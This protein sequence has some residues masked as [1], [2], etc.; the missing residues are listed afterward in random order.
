MTIADK[1]IGMEKFPGHS[2]EVQRTVDDVVLYNLM[3]LA[4]T[5]NA[6]TQVRA[7]A[8]LKISELKGWLSR[9]LKAIKDES[10]RAHVLF[11]I[12]QIDRYLQDPQ[13]VVFPRPAEAPPGQP[14]G[15]WGFG[16]D[17]EE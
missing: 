17:W 15:D 1:V 3:V 5:E 10:Q 8:A 12:S 16:L 6:T 2:A 14:I 9:E 13:K 11:A 4:N 7:I